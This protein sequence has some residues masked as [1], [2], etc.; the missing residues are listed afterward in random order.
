MYPRAGRIHMLVVRRDIW[1]SDSFRYLNSDEVKGGIKF[2]IMWGYLVHDWCGIS[3]GSTS[4]LKKLSPKFRVHD[5]EVDTSTTQTQ[6]L[7]QS[8]YL[9][10]SNSLKSNRHHVTPRRHTVRRTPSLTAR[11][12]ISTDPPTFTTTMSN[13]ANT[14]PPPEFS[15]F[16]LI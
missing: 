6:S 13:R 4:P 3:V 8:H 5:R 2:G 12:L 16:K 9:K 7:T 11:I 14:L 10:D 15:A 1:N